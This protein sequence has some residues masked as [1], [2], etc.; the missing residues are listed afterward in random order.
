MS[1][2][3]ISLSNIVTCQLTIRP[4]GSCFVGS[5]QNDIVSINSSSYTDDKYIFS[6]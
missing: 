5:L 6:K 3:Q 2:F 1:E 4:T